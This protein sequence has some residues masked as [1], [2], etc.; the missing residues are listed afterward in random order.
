MY[1]RIRVRTDVR[2]TDEDMKRKKYVDIGSNRSLLHIQL[3]I[4]FG[5][6]GTASIFKELIK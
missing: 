6:V 3:D 4:F 1:L 2:T 5:T